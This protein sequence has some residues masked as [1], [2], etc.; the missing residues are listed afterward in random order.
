LGRKWTE[1]YTVAGEWICHEEVL[2]APELSQDQ[3]QGGVRFGLAH[4]ASLARG[5]APLIGFS[6][7]KRVCHKPDNSRTTRGASARRPSKSVAHDRK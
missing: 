1:V 5:V 7:Y 3:C 4:E 6:D 2:Q